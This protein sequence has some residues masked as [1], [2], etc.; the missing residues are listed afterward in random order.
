MKPTR[1]L[2]IAVIAAAAS[3][4]IIANASAHQP[5]AHRAEVATVSLRETSLGMILVNPSG[6]TLFQFTRDKKKRDNCQ[7]ISGCAEVWPALT[8][9]SPTAG[10]GIHASKLSTIM[11][12]NGAHQVTY[13]GRPLYT[14]S[15]DSGPGQ[16]S[17]VGAFQ[18]GGYWFADNAKGRQVR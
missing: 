10:P 12:A 17:Y 11:L 9:T 8:A 2:L 16:T 15:G 5:R 4:A 13:Y 14:Y 3:W 1:I 18:F 6:R 7:T